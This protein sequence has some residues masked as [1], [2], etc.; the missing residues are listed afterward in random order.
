MAHYNLIYKDSKADLRKKY[1]KWKEISLIAAL[2]L[3]TFLFYAFQRFEPSLEFV[4]TS[5]DDIPIDVIPP[6]V[7]RTKPPAP[8]RPK[9]PVEAEDEA[10][11]RLYRSLRFR[12]S[13][14]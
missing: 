4:K 13:R 8:V 5:P 6:T 12:K 7:Q 2:L 3:T 1:P 10:K 9:I 11:S 14:W